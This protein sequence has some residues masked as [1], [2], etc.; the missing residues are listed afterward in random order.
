MCEKKAFQGTREDWARMSMEITWT[1][2]MLKRRRIL[3]CEDVW[4]EDMDK[5]MEKMLVREG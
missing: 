3:G 1:L 4:Q 2:R 5:R